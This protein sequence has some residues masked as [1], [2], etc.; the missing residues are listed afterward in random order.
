[1]RI[2]YEFIVADPADSQLLAQAPIDELPFPYFRCFGLDP[3]NIASLYFLANDKPYCESYLYQ[4]SVL[5]HDDKTCDSIV[6][7]PE[8]FCDSLADL[9]SERISDIID[10]WEQTAGLSLSYWHK[11]FKRNVVLN[12]VELSKQ[13]L[14]HSKSL[15]LKVC[16]DQDAKSNRATL[17]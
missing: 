12:L 15:I 4:F 9:N 5:H 8:S 3:V 6:E 7:L 1:M 2:T 13:C 17:H 14:D 16:V 10:N 11:D